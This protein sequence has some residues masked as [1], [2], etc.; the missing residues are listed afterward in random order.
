MNKWGKSVPLPSGRDCF[1]KSKITWRKIKVVIASVSEALTVFLGFWCSNGRTGG[2]AAANFVKP[3]R[4]GV[5]VTWFFSISKIL[6]KKKYL[7]SCKICSK[8]IRSDLLPNLDP[9]K[10]CWQ[11]QS[12]NFQIVFWHLGK[13]KKSKFAWKSEQ[14]GNEFEKIA[15]MTKTNKYQFM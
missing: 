1:V 3:Y 8:H 7:R 13:K 12:R 15:K 2:Q 6:S 10:R 9:P 11:N 14:N 5:L 4:S